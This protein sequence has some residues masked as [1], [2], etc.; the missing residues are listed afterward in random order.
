MSRLRFRIS[1]SLD[2]YVAGP[3]QSIKDPLGVGVFGAVEERDGVLDQA[4]QTLL[5]LALAVV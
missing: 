4:F 5:G 2:G 1:M 3:N